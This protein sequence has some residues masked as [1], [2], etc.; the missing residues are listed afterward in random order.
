MQNNNDDFPGSL[1]KVTFVKNPENIN[2]KNVLIHKTNQNKNKNKRSKTKTN[3][4]TTKGELDFDNKT[5]KWTYETEENI[6]ILENI[7]FHENKVAFNDAYTQVLKSLANETDMRTKD[8]SALTENIKECMNSIESQN[9]DD[10]ENS[11]KSTHMM[12]L[13]K[14][15]GNHKRRIAEIKNNNEIKVKWTTVTERVDLCPN[16][17]TRIPEWNNVV[18][19]WVPQNSV[20]QEPT[21]V[22]IIHDT[23]YQKCSPRELWKIKEVKLEFPHKITDNIKQIN[24]KQINIDG[25]DIIICSSNSVDRFSWE[26]GHHLNNMSSFLLD[27][28]NIYFSK[29]NNNNTIFFESY[30]FTTGTECISSLQFKLGIHTDI[31]KSTEYHINHFDLIPD[32]DKCIFSSF[33]SNQNEQHLIVVINND[34]G[35]IIYEHIIPFNIRR[36]VL[37]SIPDTIIAWNSI[38]HS[39]VELN[40]KQ[41]NILQTHKIDEFKNITIQDMCIQGNHLF[42]LATI[43]SS[44]N[45]NNTCYHIDTSTFKIIKKKTNLEN[46]QRITVSDDRLFCYSLDGKLKY[47]YFK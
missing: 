21:K 18:V 3:N 5:L 14:C 20:T 31:F 37:G 34:T 33:K 42:V 36:F 8:I 22:Q 19:M 25:T 7:L 13:I 11:D 23:Q 38:Q 41:G 45:S 26:N 44:L 24:I 27:N 28:K 29:I 16:V 2:N 32:E 47:T 46:I 9:D 4:I 43:Y 15:R 1:I 17:I 6:L 30:C 12:S 39:F 10:N 40:Y 35:N